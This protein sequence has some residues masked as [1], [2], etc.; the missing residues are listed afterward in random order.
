M[1]KLFL[2]V[3]FSISFNA[4]ANTVNVQE[5]LTATL[6]NI[7][8]KN[9]IPAMSVAI[10]TSG[11]LSYI[12]GFGF[13]DDEDKKPTNSETLFRTA[14]ISKLFTAQAVMQLVEKNK[15]KLN[16]KIGHYIPRF[17]DSNITIKDLLTHSSGISDSIKP[18][19]F[20]KQRTIN[21]Y[22]D[23]VI[24]SLSKNTENKI[25]EYSDTN[26]NILG[27]IIGAV[28]DLSYEEYVYKNIL[29]PAN[30]NK[31][32]FFNSDTFYFPDTKPTY[33]GKII[34]KIDQ[35][36]YDLSFN[37]S[38]GLISSIQD[39][40]HWLKLTLAGDS[41][42]LKKQTY[43]RMLEPQVKTSWGE[44]HMGLGW[45]VY[46][47]SNEKIARHPGSIRGYKSLILA[48]PDSKNALIL[49]TNSSNTPRWEIAQSITKI[50]KQSAEW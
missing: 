15:L 13:F 45:Q 31:S 17:Q 47:S 23:S 27:A 30:M 25:F 34:A 5:E 14:S 35:R 22:L 7:R 36:P 26:F 21:S 2:I 49:L 18:V 42:I 3:I 50:L 33:K 28:S 41:S 11:E 32:G 12:R 16:E 39:L 48:F 1:H 9:D 24:Q 8:I 6:E 4:F 29:T 10:I 20:D 46:N 37:P 40:S 38:E 43:K 44:I 19:N